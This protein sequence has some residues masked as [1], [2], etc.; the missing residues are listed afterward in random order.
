MSSCDSPYLIVFFGQFVFGDQYGLHR[1][2][3]DQADRLAELF[4]MRHFKEEQRLILLWR[5][6]SPAC[7]GQVVH[8][9]QSPRD[10]RQSAWSCW[11]NVHDGGIITFG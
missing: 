5:C 4:F 2:V 6:P 9:R 1:M 8:H 10:I 11:S 3:A 7:S